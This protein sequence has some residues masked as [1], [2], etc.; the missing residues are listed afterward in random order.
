M[1]MIP[2]VN[3]SD[4]AAAGY[5]NGILYIE[6]LSGTMYRYFDVPEAVFNSLMNANSRGRYFHTFIKNHYRYQRL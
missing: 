6:F 5:E 1:N 4:L 3:S 2:I